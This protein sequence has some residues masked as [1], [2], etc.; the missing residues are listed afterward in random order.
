LPGLEEWA[1][2]REW[3]TRKDA[4]ELGSKSAVNRGLLAL[5][6]ENKLE[7]RLTGKKEELRLRR[8]EPKAETFSEDE[9]K[10]VVA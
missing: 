9:K 3:F 6:N 1:L 7:T 10:E 2:R 8:P 4:A 5:I